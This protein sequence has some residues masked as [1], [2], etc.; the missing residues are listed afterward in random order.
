MVRVKIDCAFTPTAGG[1]K[2]AARA[3]GVG[4]AAT[5]VPD[6]PTLALA[7][8]PLWVMLNNALAPPNTAGVKMTL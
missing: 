3:R 4:D 2:V 1:V 6:K 7:P 5:P 8:G